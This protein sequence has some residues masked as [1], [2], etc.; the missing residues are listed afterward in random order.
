VDTEPVEENGLRNNKHL[1]N[2]SPAGASLSTAKRN[3]DN[4]KPYTGS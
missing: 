3:A 4:L 2:P 1:L